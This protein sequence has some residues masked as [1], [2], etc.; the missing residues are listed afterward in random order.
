MVNLKSHGYGKA[1]FDQ[2]SETD[3]QTLM[4]SV[5]G[6]GREFYVPEIKQVY[7][8]DLQNLIEFACFFTLQ[9][10]LDCYNGKKNCIQW[11]LVFDLH[12]N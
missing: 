3:N 5:L 11:Y 6:G 4:P 9:N 2:R 1:N 7:L 10:E 8:N 12:V